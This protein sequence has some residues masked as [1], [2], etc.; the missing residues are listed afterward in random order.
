[1]DGTLLQLGLFLTATFVAAVVTGLAGFAFGLVASAIWLHAITPVQSATLIVLYGLLVQGYAV[2]KLRH[3]LNFSLLWPFLVGGGLGVPVGVSIL[4][5]ARPEHMRAGIGAVL[6][7]YSV[8]SLLRPNLPPAKSAHAVADGTAGFLNGV[9]GGMTGLSAILVIV[10]C[11][12]RGWSRDVQRSVFQPSTVFVFAMTA[13][14]LGARG[15]IT[16]DTLK[17]FVIGLPVVFIGIQVGMKLYGRLDEAGFRR[18]VLILLLVSGVALVGPWIV[19][20]LRS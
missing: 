15:E 20:M 6:I 16:H 13:T 4:G 3:A 8:Y 17:L 12:L 1:M 5:L 7:A 9:L 18:V 11:G 2:W 14:W 19:A 10:W